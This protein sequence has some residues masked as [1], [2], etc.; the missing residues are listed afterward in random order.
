MEN[1]LEGSTI[2]L[3]ERHDNAPKFSLDRI[4]LP[5]KKNIN[6]NEIFNCYRRILILFDKIFKYK[7]T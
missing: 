6:K 7:Y 4:N 3:K 5:R 1:F 2:N